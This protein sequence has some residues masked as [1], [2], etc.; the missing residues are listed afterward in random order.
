[1]VTELNVLPDVVKHIG[2]N[3]SVRKSQYS[4]V[5]LFAL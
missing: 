1:M 4:A 5:L 2:L 3:V